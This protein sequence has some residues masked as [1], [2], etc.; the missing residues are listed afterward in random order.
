M[1]AKTKL[2]V[3]AASSCGGTAAQILELGFDAST[4]AKPNDWW[5]SG[6]AK[7]FADGIV[8]SFSFA[9]RRILNH[10]LSKLV[11]WSQGSMIKMINAEFGAAPERRLKPGTAKISRDTVNLLEHR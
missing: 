4:S 6:K 11:R 3:A 1:A 10:F 9:L 7:A 5:K 8:A 2:R